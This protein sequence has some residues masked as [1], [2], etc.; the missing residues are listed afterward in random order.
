M[1]TLCG[2]VTFCVVVLMRKAEAVDVVSSGS[3]VP[4]WKSPRAYTRYHVPGECGIAVALSRKTQVPI[5]DHESIE[6]LQEE[7]LRLQNLLELANLKIAELENET[8]PL[9]SRRDLE[10]RTVHLH[11]TRF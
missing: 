5:S 7:V 3:A 11:K 2:A 8:L 4:S 9:L 6:R 10:G 1:T